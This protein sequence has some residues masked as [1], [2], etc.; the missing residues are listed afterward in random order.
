M[1][2]HR[3]FFAI[4]LAALVA[5]PA[6]AAH[7]APAPVFTESFENCTHADPATLEVHT[8]LSNPITVD[9]WWNTAADCPGWDTT[10][11]AWLTHYVSGPPFPD[12]EYALWL[13]EY[14]QGVAAVTVGGLT[15]GTE[16]TI[17]FDAWTDN[18]PRDT[19]LQVEYV[20][21]AAM[22]STT[23]QLPGGSGPT[24]FSETFVTDVEETNLYFYGATGTDA[25]PIIDNIT[26]TA[27][28]DNTDETMYKNSLAQTGFD[29]IALTV[30]GVAFFAGGL[31]FAVRRLRSQR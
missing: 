11:G 25:S 20:S 28:S 30:S 21:A 22:P 6:T 9:I 4:G 8:A 24:H 12:G 7:S 15:M 10:S 27:T 31:V 18:D 1:A 26:V 29:P 2:F 16:Y 19:W 23:F 14:P 3:V 17:A 5:V 13:N